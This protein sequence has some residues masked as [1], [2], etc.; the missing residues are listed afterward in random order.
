MSLD[1]Y[2][3]SFL[4]LCDAELRPILLLGN[5]LRVGEVAKVLK[6]KPSDISRRLNHIRELIYS[7]RDYNTDIKSMLKCDIE[8]VCSAIGAKVKKTV[9][10]S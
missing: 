7:Y 8:E 6:V 3:M 10:V 5:G 4:R 9:K 1:Y 2:R